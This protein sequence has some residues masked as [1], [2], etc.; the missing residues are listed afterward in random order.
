M[1]ARV[2]IFASISVFISIDLNFDLA[3]EYAWPSNLV[4]FWAV[5]K[6]GFFI[7][8]IRIPH[9]RLHRNH[10]PRMLPT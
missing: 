10:G 7:H 9:V 8:Q 6:R 5:H 2:R 3:G 4:V 1:A